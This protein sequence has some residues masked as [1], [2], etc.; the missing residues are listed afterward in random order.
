MFIAA[1][2]LRL[3]FVRFLPVTSCAA[4]IINWLALLCG[5]LANNEARNIRLRAKS[6]RAHGERVIANDSLENSGKVAKKTF[7]RR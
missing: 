4:P 2:G 7:L 3:F 1:G 6:A 5:K